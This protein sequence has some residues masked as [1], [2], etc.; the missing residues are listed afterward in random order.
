MDFDSSAAKALPQKSF[1]F[2]PG[3]SPVVD[4]ICLQKTVST[5][6]PVLRM[7]NR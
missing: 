5:V 6:F 2:S 3:F 7:R 4:G 1:S